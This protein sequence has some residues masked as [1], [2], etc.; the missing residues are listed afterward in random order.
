MRPRPI[1]AFERITLDSIALGLLNVAMNW[2]WLAQV[3][4]TTTIALWSY[5]LG[6]ALIVTLT[7][8][9]SRK[10]SKVAMWIM[11]VLFVLGLVPWV[12]PSVW[13]GPLTKNIGMVVV[14]GLQLLALS[15][16]FTPS[17]RLWMSKR[18]EQAELHDTF[19]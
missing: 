2:T 1:V 5:G 7:L 18:D 9:V 19:V 12:Q 17:A 11:V 8:L 4:A 16:L 3:G 13:A 15:R 14:T 10:R 6:A